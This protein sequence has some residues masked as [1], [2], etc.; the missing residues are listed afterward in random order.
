MVRTTDSG[1]IL[2][3]QQ[4]LQV[5][6]GVV[7]DGSFVELMAR[8]EPVAGATVQVTGQI[9]G[10]MVLGSVECTDLPGG[11]GLYL[12]AD[13]RLGDQLVSFTA[14]DE[15]NDDGSVGKILG[16]IGDV[17]F[18]RNEGVT[19]EASPDG[20]TFDESEINVVTGED[21]LEGTSSGSLFFTGEVACP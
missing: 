11:G 7:N 20:L 5:L 2:D 10:E 1:T 6:A 15:V 19:F 3:S 21:I 18:S 12:A 4:H 8:D 14:S 17:T 9:E 13:G 16:T